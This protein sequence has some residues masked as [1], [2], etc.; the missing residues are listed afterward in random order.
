MEPP[1]LARLSAPP[2]RLL[3]SMWRPSAIS[4]RCWWWPI[5]PPRVPRFYSYG[6]YTD[7]SLTTGKIGLFSWAQQSIDYDFARVQKVAGRGLQVSSAFGNPDPPVGLNDLPA[8]SSVTASVTNQVYDQPGV[9]RILTG[10]QGGGSVP[11]TGTTNSVTF[12]LNNLSLINWTWST[13][14]HAHCCGPG[15]R[16]WSSPPTAAGSRPAPWC[17]CRSA[18]PRQH[19]PGLGRQRDFHG[20]HSDVRHE[21]TAHDDRPLCGGFGRGRPGG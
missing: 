10:W 16:P 20:G 6:P 15:K 7:A 19:L 2:T 21:W 13:E 1:F 18:Q 11:A 14:Y 8:G 5:Q 12:T 17:R 3:T 9:R 4:C